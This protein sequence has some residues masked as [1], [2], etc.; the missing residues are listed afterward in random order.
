MDYEGLFASMLQGDRRPCQTV[1]QLFIEHFAMSVLQSA[2][3]WRKR[4]FIR[5]SKKV[6][7][8]LYH[9]MQY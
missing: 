2:L 8:K 6:I 9:K 4:V 7:I 5:M 3:Q 1:L